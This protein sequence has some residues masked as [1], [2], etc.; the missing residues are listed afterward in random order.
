MLRAALFDWGGTLMDDEWT[1]EIALEGNTAGIAALARAGL[2]AP[3]TFSRYLWENERELFA[4]GADDE[5]DVAD[6]MRSSFA[7]HG[8]ELSGDDVR[9][10]LQTTQDVWSSYY[11]LGA[12]THA[13]LES[14]RGRGLKL[15]LVS[16]TA[17]PEWLLRP[18]LERQG[19]VERLDA[20]VLS[21]EVGKR[22]PHP[23]IFERALAEVQAEPGE[24]LFVGDRLV[25]DV[26]GASRVGLRTVQALWFRADEPADGAEPDHEAFTPMDVLNVV[27]RLLAG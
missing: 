8:V 22:K 18:V 16:N 2:P 26:A 10:F 24:A 6:V 20:I 7:H 1:A 13:L 25:A 3:E 12:S 5:I 11:T 14:L 23:A 9:L 21:S 17:S 4:L 27:D 19:L 15:A